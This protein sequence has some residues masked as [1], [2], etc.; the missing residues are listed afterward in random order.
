MIGRCTCHEPWGIHGGKASCR[1]FRYWAL[2]DFNET[3][4]EK[5]RASLISSA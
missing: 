4:K 3:L 1:H 5:A 2:G